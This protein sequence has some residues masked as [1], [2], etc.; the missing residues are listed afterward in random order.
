MGVKKQNNDPATDP[1]AGELKKI[2]YSDPG[3]GDITF[4]YDRLGRKKTVA[5]I[6]GTH[7]FSYNA[8]LQFV[9]ELN[10][11][12]TITRTYDET[13]VDGRNIGFT[14]APVGGSVDYE[15]EYGF[16]NVGRMG[17]VTYTDSNNSEHEFKYNYMSGSDLLT[18]WQT[19]VT[20]PT[21]QTVRAY[22][23]DR[24]LIDYVEN[25][26]GSTLATLSKYDYTTDAIGRRT[27]RD[28][29]G[30]EFSS[31]INNDFGYNSRSEVTSATMG[32]G[33]YAYA[34]DNIGNRKTHTSPG[35]SEINYTANDLNQYAAI[36]GRTGVR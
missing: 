7:T 9:S 15:V 8:N 4:T 10:P 2:D 24:D 36:T 13:I 23:L 25:K 14:H 17:S 1:G 26:A 31:T 11:L 30:S 22:E 6:M 28:D 32:L 3:T 35:V 34:Y 29:T 20:S 5:D 21:F 16:D 27:A 33:D 19:P 12:G 18:G